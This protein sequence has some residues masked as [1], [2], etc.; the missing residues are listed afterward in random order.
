MNR[1][2]CLARLALVSGLPAL[3]HAGPPGNRSRPLVDRGGIVR[4][5]RDRKRLALVFTSDR[6]AEGAPRVLDALRRQQVKA[7]LFLTGRF[8][9]ERDFQGVLEQARGEGHDI[10]PHSDQHLLYATWD[11]PP[12]LLVSR[13]EFLADLGANDRALAAVAR[14]PGRFPYF[15]PPFEHY[16]E[17]IARWAAEA[18]RTLINLTPGTLSHTDYMEDDDPRFVPAD[19]IVASV[20]RAERAD[21]D[22]LNGFLLL[23]HLGA[24]P[25]R[26][27]DHLHDSLDD[28]LGAV[29]DRGYEFVRVPDLLRPTA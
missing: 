29:K 7:A 13:G 23:M 18:G 1:R 27:R 10:G 21:P 17:E 20:R 26:T 5:P 25:R 15:L 22:G 4:G 9:R 12:R 28:L 6:Y 3:T 14:E 11:R 19:R 24:G 2:D 16:T 8:L